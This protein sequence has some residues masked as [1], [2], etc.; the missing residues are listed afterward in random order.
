MMRTLLNGP[1]RFT[2]VNEARRRGYY[3]ERAIGLDKRD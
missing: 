3:F 2:P 1:L